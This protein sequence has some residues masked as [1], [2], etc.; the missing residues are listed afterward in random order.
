MSCLIIFNTNDLA[1]AHRSGITTATT[2]LGKES[3]THESEYS[4]TL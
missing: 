1:R 3:F 4:T 2:M